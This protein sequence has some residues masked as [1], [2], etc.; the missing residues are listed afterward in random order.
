M[1][2]KPPAASKRQLAGVPF[3]LAVDFAPEVIEIFAD[4]D[5]KPGNDDPSRCKAL[6]RF[7][8]RRA[9]KGAIFWSAKM[10]LDADG[11]AA[12]RGRLKGKAL[13]PRDGQNDTTFHFAN[14]KGLA[15][16]AV[17]YI[18]VVVAASKPSLLRAWR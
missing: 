10:A 14:G 16:E 9:N 6:L 3:E 15:S 2:F 1:V 17:P 12:G 8:A 7:P 13:D 18:V 5:K 11:P 4:A